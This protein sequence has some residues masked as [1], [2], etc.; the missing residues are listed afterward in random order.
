MQTV[1][2]ASHDDSQLPNGTR[3]IVDGHGLG[4]V[5]AAAAGGEAIQSGRLHGVF[6]V[7]N[8]ESSGKVHYSC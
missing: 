3:V 5:R 8:H 6:C 7:E 4:T 1:P 2:G